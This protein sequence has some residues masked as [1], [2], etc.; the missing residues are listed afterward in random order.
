MKKFAILTV[1][2]S[3]LFLSACSQDNN[4]LIESTAGKITQKDLNE[5]LENLYGESMLRELTFRKILESKY[6]VSDKEINGYLELYKEDNGITSDEQLLSSLAQSPYKTIDE[7]KNIYLKQE[8][9][10]FKAIENEN[11]L[12]VSDKE[13][14]QLFDGIKTQV[15][16]SHILVKDE[17]AAKKV[18]DELENGKSFEQL[19]KDYSTDSSAANG[20]DLGWFGKGKMVKEFEE[21]AFSLEVGKTSGSVK[22]QFGYHIIKVTDKK[23]LKLED[24]KD[25][26]HMKALKSLVN[27]ELSKNPNVYTE[28]LT[29]LQKESKIKV[30][31]EKYKDLF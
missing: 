24:V 11:K 28:F 20:G 16:A 30:K 18:L 17:A 2:A 4:V 5:E 10:F 9:L 7:F 23:E 15:K 29:K 19:A 21:A 26:L 22:S 8:I 31:E 12:K 27:D 6:K 1:L 25:M 3:A 14:Q 13:I